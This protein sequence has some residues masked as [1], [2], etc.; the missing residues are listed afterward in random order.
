MDLSLTGEGMVE[1]ILVVSAVI[2]ILGVIYSIGKDLFPYIQNLF[3]NKN[4]SSKAEDNIYKQVTRQVNMEYITDSGL[5]DLWEN[6]GYKL[7]WST[8]SNVASWELKGYEIM[9]GV[10]DQKKERF[11]LEILR[12]DGSVDLVLMGKKENKEV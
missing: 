7:R 5:K 2:A 1:A 10:D 8:P 9:Y 12:H 6:E 3:N 11:S 4:H